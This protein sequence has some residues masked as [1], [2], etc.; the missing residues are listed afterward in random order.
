MEVRE[1]GGETAAECRIA[2][3]LEIEDDAPGELVTAED[4]GEGF[5]LGLAGGE[6]AGVG[7]GIVAVDVDRRAGCDAEGETG[8]GVV[9]VGGDEAIE[10]AAQEQAAESDTDE[11]AMQ[12][13]GARDRA[14][15]YGVGGWPMV[16]R[17]RAR[18]RVGGRWQGCV[19][20]CGNFG[21]RAKALT[22]MRSTSGFRPGRDDC[23]RMEV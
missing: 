15:R 5:E 7:G 17:K 11:P 13:E 1:A 21:Q 9:L 23:F 12:P 4:V 6:G 22:Y 8:A 14:Q 3:E 16:V 10:E 19:L 2:I 20:H 18:L